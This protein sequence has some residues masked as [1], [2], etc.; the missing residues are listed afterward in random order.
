M[1]SN[2]EHWGLIV[3]TIAFVSARRQRKVSAGYK[4]WLIIIHCKDTS[5]LMFCILPSAL[6]L[7]NVWSQYY[8]NCTVEFVVFVTHFYA[9]EMHFLKLISL[10]FAM[11][12][13]QYEVVKSS[14]NKPTIN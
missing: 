6:T 1:Y 12:F 5:C 4:K 9:A 3:I 2:I 10:T 14:L 8:V 7:K 13:L 11:L